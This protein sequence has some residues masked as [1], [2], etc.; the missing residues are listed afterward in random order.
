MAFFDA[1]GGRKAT[2]QT[3]GDT[4]Y[5]H[6]LGCREALVCQGNNDF[7]VRGATAC[8]IGRQ[9]SL[10][11]RCRQAER[12]PLVAIAGLTSR[13]FL[14]QCRC[15]LTM[16]GEAIIRFVEACFRAFERE[17]VAYCIM[18][19]A[20]E[21]VAGDAHDVDLAVDDTKLAQAEACIFRTAEELDWKILFRTGSAG[22]KHNIKCYNFYQ[23]QPDGTPALAH[24]DIFTSFVW[25]SHILIDCRHTLEDMDTSSL[26]HRISPVTEA[27]TKLFVRLLYNG[28]IKRKY[29]PHI[30]EVYRAE[31]DKVRACMENFLNTE[32]AAE[33]C[34]LATE[35]RWEE[36]E[37]MRSRIVSDIKKKTA[38]Y[39][40]CY[41][42]YLVRKAFRRISVMVALEG[43]Y[44]EV[45]QAIIETLPAVV[46]NTFSAEST[47]VYHY[48]PRLLG[49]TA[50]G[51]N[52]SP[53]SGENRR[54]YGLLKSWA[55]LLLCVADDI[56]GY[57]GPVRWHLCKG[58]LVVFNGYYDDLLLNPHRHR[59]GLSQRVIRLFRPLVPSADVTMLLDA[60][61][62]AQPV[63]NLALETGI[64]LVETQHRHYIRRCGGRA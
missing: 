53:K 50:C 5:A 20:D 32:T 6:R 13:G 43:G 40:L 36:I 29:V 9:Y 34:R 16:S 15:C 52:S 24:I 11:W 46:G 37:A 17:G 55:K 64:A 59:L 60:E 27:V 18:R 39:R 25:C 10:L 23:M 31:P 14:L 1:A 51:E 63:A 30:T 28:Y 56:L 41:W 2:R 4:K 8:C 42:L 35:E 22:D 54:P 61:K 45:N 49:R 26:Y 38:T 58:H 19:N 21:V 57:W 47:Y 3:G 7:H 12:T 62:A 33:V 44:E 48:R